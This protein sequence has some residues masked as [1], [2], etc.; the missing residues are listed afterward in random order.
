[1][2]DIANHEVFRFMIP[3][4]GFS[5]RYYKFPMAEY[6]KD[7]GNPEE[8]LGKIKNGP[9]KFHMSPTYYLQCKWLYP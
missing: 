3:L 2:I 9:A 4:S 7:I 5:E 6:K 8:S 1:M